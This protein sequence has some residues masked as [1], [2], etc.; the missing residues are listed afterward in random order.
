MFLHGRRHEHVWVKLTADAPAG[1]SRLE[2]SESVDW[3]SGMEVVIT[4]TSL[5]F[6]EAE[7]H[8]ISEVTDSGRTL[9][10][11]EPLEYLHISQS[12]TLNNGKIYSNKAEVGLLTRNI[13]IISDE[14][15]EHYGGRV[16]VGMRTVQSDDGIYST[17]RGKIPQTHTRNVLKCTP[18]R[19]CGPI[20]TY[21]WI[22]LK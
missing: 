6:R 21:V 5:G 4:P 2:L 9:V 18:D 10:L 12:E 20:G 1:S 8:I 19:S 3:E 7:R 16:V 22:R 11:T 13:R 14:S 15:D 17:L